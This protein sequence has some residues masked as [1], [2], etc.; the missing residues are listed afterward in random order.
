MLS[1]I[2]DIRQQNKVIPEKQGE[3]YNCPFNGLKTVSKTNFRQNHMV[4]LSLE[5]ITGSLKVKLAK[6]CR[7]EY[8]RG[9]GWT[10]RTLNICRGFL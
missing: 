8:W 10:E 4:S 3:F 2:L 6:A 9:E 5:D 7:K 1:K